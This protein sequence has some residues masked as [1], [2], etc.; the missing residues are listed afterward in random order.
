M[1]TASAPAKVIILGEHTALYGNPA[2]VMALDIRSRVSVSERKDNRVILTAPEL[3]LENAPVERKMRGTEMIQKGVD[4]V[5]GG[6]DIKVTS[7]IPIASGLGSSA[8]IASALMMALRKVNGQESGMRLLAQEALK[9][10]NLVHSISSGLDPFAVTYGGLSVYQDQK[11]RKLKVNEYPNL[12]IAHSGI[13]SDT[14]S[15]V[16][17]MHRIWKDEPARFAGFLDLSKELVNLG[18][19]AIKNKDWSALG[20][21]MDSNHTLLSD[22]GISCDRIDKMVKAARQSGAMGAK[23]CGAGRGGIM[24]ALVNEKSKI[25]VIEALSKMDAKIIE[26]KVSEE[27]TRLE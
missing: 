18:E 22:M 1:I 16:E 11:I 8:S 13:T 21:L 7:D 27:G 10:E 23:I 24:V 12:L 9:C 17:D 2:L 6:Y 19:T 15:I 4:L 26:S 5:G 25:K 14:G 3:G 20:T